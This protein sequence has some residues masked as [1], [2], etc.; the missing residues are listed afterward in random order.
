MADDPAVPNALSP[1]VRNRSVAEGD[2]PDALRR[3]YYVDG[4][5]GAGLGFYVDAKVAA[6]AFRDRGRQLVAAR[7]DPNTIRD[8]T[9]IA[10]HRGWSIVVARGETSF[11]REAWLVGRSAGIEVRGYRP[12]ERDIQEL[13]RRIERRDRSGGEPRRR[14]RE[15]DDPG[16]RANLRVVEAVVRARVAE[17]S[18]QQRI[19]ASARERVA[20]WLERGARFE[21][22]QP[23]GRAAVVEAD[24]NRERRRER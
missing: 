5:G 24:L 19:M 21:P 13:D 10:Q 15:A 8:M 23:T 14:A 2:V 18:A 22:L 4:R 20:G 17:P 7:S 1:G 6:P 11:R 16:A 12:T 9:A 3:R